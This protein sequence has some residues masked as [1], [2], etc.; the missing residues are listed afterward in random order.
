M[1]LIS[2]LTAGVAAG[3]FA[4]AAVYVSLVEHPA[5]LSCGLS[6]AIAEFAPS[7]RRATAMQAALALIGTIAA[8]VRWG[9]GGR[10]GWLLGA[11][12]LGSVIPFTLVVIRP[13]NQRLLDASLPP[14]SP[15]TAALLARW[16]RLHAVRT[17]V[18]LA[19][20]ATFLF[21]Q[22]RP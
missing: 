3:L 12:L 6:V 16:G 14:D 7:Y 1:S 10:P 9:A 21:L 2:E 20:F 5:R 22:S 4:G 13:T 11:I 17:A 18:G 8:L 19:A 15:E